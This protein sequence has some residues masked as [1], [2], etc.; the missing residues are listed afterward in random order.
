MR[1]P[2]GIDWVTPQVP[3]LGIEGTPE[4]WSLQ[5][6]ADELAAS[7]GGVDV[8]VGHDLGGVLAAMLAQPGQTLVLSGTALSL[9]WWMV[10]Q[11]ARPGL[12]R[13]F[14][15]HYGGRRFIEQGA[16]PEHRDALL[17]TFLDHGSDWSD[18]MRCVAKGMRPPRDLARRLRDCQVHLFWGTADPWYPRWVAEAIARSTQ[19]QVHWL[20]SGHFA[21]WEAAPEFSRLLEAVLLERAR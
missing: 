16:L 14:Y 1:P 3:G 9:Y 18:R 11:T 6:C 5:G 7:L 10:R 20:E 8:W 13:F 2:D 12:Q 17:K 15:Q 4:D 19:A 21:P